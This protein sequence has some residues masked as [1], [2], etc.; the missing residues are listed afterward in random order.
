[1]T[2][3]AGI[4]EGGKIPFA[5]CFLFVSQK[6]SCSHSSVNDSA[7]LGLVKPTTLLANRLADELFAAKTGPTSSHYRRCA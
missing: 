3:V 6:V 2:S 1:M 5:N 4:E 7:N